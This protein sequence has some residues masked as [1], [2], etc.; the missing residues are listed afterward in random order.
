MNGRGHVLVV[1]TGNVCRSPYLERRLRQELAGTGI[2]VSSAGTQGLVGRDMDP[3]SRELLVRAGGSPE[4]FAARLLTEELVAGADVVITAAR[5]HRAAAARL[6]PAALRRTLTLRD[7][8]D[9]LEGVGPEDLSPEPTDRSWVRH[10]VDV[11]TAR[12]GLVPARQE[13]VDITD[14]IG[15]GPAV[16]E[17]MAAEID[18][19]IVPVVAALRGGTRA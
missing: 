17:Q 5:E 13:G 15:H 12:R 7:L 3:G 18:A 1:C 19:A 4:G 2:E 10:V 9:L 11:A 6:H 8:A 14:P 16:F